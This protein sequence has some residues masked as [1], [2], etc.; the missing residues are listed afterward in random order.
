[1]NFKRIRNDVYGIRNMEA[2]IAPTPS[3]FKR[4]VRKEVKH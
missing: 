1:M 4:L 3:I 2:N